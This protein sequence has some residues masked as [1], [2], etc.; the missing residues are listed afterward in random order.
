[1]G[2]Q[3]IPDRTDGQTID[4]TWFDIIQQALAV[5]Q[6]PRNGSGVA[7]H[8]AGSLGTSSIAF[9]N[10]YIRTMKL[11]ASTSGKI[12][13]LSAPASL[14]NDYAMT[15]PDA[16]PAATRPFRITS[17]GI[18][19]FDRIVTDDITDGSVTTAKLSA[20]NSQTSSSCGS[21]N[22]NSTSYVD[23]T[24]LTATITTTGRPVQIMC[25]ASSSPESYFAG[26]TSAAM[27]IK[28]LRGASAVS[29][30]QLNSQVPPSSILHYDPV[31][32]GTYTYKLQAKTASGATAVFAANVILVIREV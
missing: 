32:A 29:E 11:R 16:L 1:M 28:I 18:I 15:L 2:T 31:A 27:S 30:N 12:A 8:E 4:E 10:A 7:T 14:A 21:F 20:V 25:V 3:T 26:F 17:G 6:V 22:T 13:S 19:T 5:D 23:I 9:L 24:N